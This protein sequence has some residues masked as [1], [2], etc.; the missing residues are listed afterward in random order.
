MRTQT[1]WGVGTKADNL[2]MSIWWGFSCWE[3]VLV[4]LTLREAAVQGA[5]AGL[6]RRLCRS[7]VANPYDSSLKQ[8]FAFA[9]LSETFISLLQNTL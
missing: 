1:K 3:F 5:G 7:P 8:D 6:R 2:A 4:S 9:C